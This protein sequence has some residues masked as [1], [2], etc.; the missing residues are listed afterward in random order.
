VLLFLFQRAAQR[1]ENS[2][3]LAGRMG[4]PMKSCFRDIKI[5]SGKATAQS[6]QSGILTR[7]WGDINYSYVSTKYKI[8]A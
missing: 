2:C 6:T 5:K 4:F 1:F 8:P 7:L 3:S